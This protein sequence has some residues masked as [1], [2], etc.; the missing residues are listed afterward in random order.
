MQKHGCHSHKTVLQN[1]KNAMPW[2]GFLTLERYMQLSATITLEHIYKN[3]FHV[4]QPYVYR[5]STCFE[6][7]CSFCILFFRA[8]GCFIKL[9]YQKS[10]AY[11]C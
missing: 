3:M 7:L 4:N 1:E 6:A 2:D 11:F 9:V 10:Q 8:G 5:S